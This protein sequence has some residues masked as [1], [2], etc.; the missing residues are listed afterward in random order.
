MQIVSTFSKDLYS[1]SF[2]QLDVNCV[3]VTQVQVSLNKDANFYCSSINF[4]NYLYCR[5]WVVFNFFTEPRM[6]DYD[7]VH[8]DVFLDLHEFVTFRMVYSCNERIFAFSFDNLVTL[9]SRTIR[10]TS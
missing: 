2:T 9:E 3:R 8:N 4:V 1:N 10:I 5:V 7:A 6:R